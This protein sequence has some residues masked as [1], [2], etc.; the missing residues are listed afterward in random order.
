MPGP[1]ICTPLACT[2]TA[3]AD[4]VSKLKPKR[5]R[6][7]SIRVVPPANSSTALVICTQV[8]ASMPPKIT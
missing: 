6:A 1:M 5:L 7:I 3:W 4:S 2:A 8:V